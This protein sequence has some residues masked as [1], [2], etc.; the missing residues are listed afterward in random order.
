[1]GSVAWSARDFP[2]DSQPDTLSSGVSVLCVQTWANDDFV[3]PCGA[4]RGH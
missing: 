1:M 3:L 4:I 2:H